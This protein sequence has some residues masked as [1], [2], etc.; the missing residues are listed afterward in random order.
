MQKLSKKCL[1]VFT[2][3]FLN[4]SWADPVTWRSAS[5]LTVVRVQTHGPDHG[6]G[7]R[8]RQ[9]RGY[10][11]G[12]YHHHH[13]SDWGWSPWAAAALLGTSVYL[14]NTYSQP[15]VSTVIVSPPVVYA[16]PRVAYFCQTSQQYYPTVPVCEVPW[17]L[18]NY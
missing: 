6:Y 1:I 2:C 10:G 8:Y 7:D 15:S 5:S 14:A 17:Q 3:V 9:G 11:G 16:P 18:V 4:T 13:R 12:G